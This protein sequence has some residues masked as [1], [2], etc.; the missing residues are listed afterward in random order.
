MNKMIIG[1]QTIIIVGLLVFILTQ[2]YDPKDFLFASQGIDTDG[3]NLCG[4][5]GNKLSYIILSELPNH[6]V[7][8]YE[9]CKFYPKKYG[10]ILKVSVE[11]IRPFTVKLDTPKIITLDLNYEAEIYQIKN[12]ND[13]FSKIYR[14]ALEGK[15]MVRPVSTI[16]EKLKKHYGEDIQIIDE[17]DLKEFS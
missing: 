5:K 8:A 2:Q 15:E 6:H 3:F 1:L 7:M 14:N 17:Y 12:Y 10:D 13:D 4:M 16:I 9:K 11:Y